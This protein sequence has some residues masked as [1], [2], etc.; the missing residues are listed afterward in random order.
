MTLLAGDDPDQLH[1]TLGLAGFRR[2]QDLAYRPACDDCD[3]C[4]PIRVVARDFKMNKSFKRVWRKNA[5]IKEIEKPALATSEHYQ[6]FQNYLASRHADGGMM[7]MDYDDY[8]SMIEE[9]PVRTM[10]MEYRLPGGEL[11]GV[12]LT[13]MMNDGLSLVYSFFD[14]EYAGLSPGTYFILRHIRRS[15]LMST[16]HVYLGYWISESQK[17][18][19]KKRFQP[20]EILI[21]NNWQSVEKQTLP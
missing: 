12:C 5:H 7:D 1:N 16:P 13:D 18:F 17:M 15:Q 8:K 10:L 19:Y 14:P 21:R 6:L 9:S 2:S 20:A 4:I 11:Y 3:A